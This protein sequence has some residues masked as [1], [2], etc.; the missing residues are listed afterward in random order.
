MGKINIKK[1][2]ITLIIFCFISKAFSIES[3]RIPLHARLISLDPTK[4]QDSSSLWVARQINCQL[5]R[6]SGGVVTTEAA[7]SIRYISPLIIDIKLK[8]YQYFSNGQELTAEDVYATLNYLNKNRLTLRNIFNW[9]RKIKVAN[10]YELLIYLKKPTPNF[11]TVFSSPNYSIFERHFL[12]A[13]QSNPALWDNPVSCGNYKIIKNSSSILKILPIREGLPIDF[14]LI[15]DSQLS[16]NKVKNYDIITLKVTNN[17]PSNL[18]NYNNIKAF[19][20]YQY[21]FAFNTNVYPWNKK[22][23]RC[24]FFSQLDPKIP[25]KSYDTEVRVANDFIPSGTLGYEDNNKQ[26]HDLIHK[27]KGQ[28]LPHKS[29]FRVAFVES[30]IEKDN[31]EYYLNMVKELYPNATKETVSSYTLLPTAALKKKFDGSFFALK[32]NYLD[33]YEFLVTLAEK[34]ANVTGY[35]NEALRQQIENSQN[36]SNPE[37][38]S[39]EYR[40]IIK[41]INEECLMYPLFTMPYDTV[42]VR[43]GII[44]PDIG[45]VSIN[46][47][48]LGKVRFSNSRE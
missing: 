35:N 6:M 2:I 28:P 40:K 13:V 20:P 10:Q 22:D 36:I 16:A 24:S 7:E 5:V 3:L 26:F 8:H 46:E 14:Y 9:V 32:S 42:Y 23:A 47:Y 1:I 34:N 45:K 15:P 21:Y 17:S 29:T 4:V 19:N 18:A 33:A 12:D 37:L 48:Y 39:K 31:R 38:K 25:M 27:Y 30:A 11:L 43:K 44:T 41:K